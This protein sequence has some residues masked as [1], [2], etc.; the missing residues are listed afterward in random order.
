MLIEGRDPLLRGT[1]LLL[2]IFAVVF[3]VAGVGAL[4][5]LLPIWAFG[6]RV[7]AWLS[8]HSDGRAIGSDAL[9]AVSA[10][11]VG[12]AVV[13]GLSLLFLRK[14]IAII[15]S[16]GEGSPFVPENGAR[17]RFMGWVVLAMQVMQVST[18]LLHPWLQRAL[19][20][21]PF[22]VP[23]SLAPLVTALL[24]FILA[25]V[26]EHGTRLAEDAEGTV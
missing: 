3:V 23:F 20:H 19:A 25:R 6:D 24:L 14:L 17:L 2:A 1:R 9:L 22:F 16:V 4:A 10:I 13:A 5:A 12:F 8:A 26:F 18:L 11:L 15:D 7:M 21:H